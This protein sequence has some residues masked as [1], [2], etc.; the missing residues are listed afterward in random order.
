MP[1]LPEL[2][3]LLERIRAA[4][5][6]DRATPITERREH[7]HAGID[8]QQAHMVEPVPT[9]PRADHSV[10]VSV[11][12]I[13]VRVYRPEVG[14]AVGCHLFIHGGGWW[15]GTLDQSDLACSRLV[16]EVGCAVVSVDHRWSPEWRFPV[17]AEDCYAALSW[18]AASSAEL[19]FDPG[20]ISVGGVSSGANL[21]AATTLMARDRGGPDVIAQS[22]EVPILDLTLSPASID[23]L[24]EGYMLTRER[25]ALEVADY[26]DPELRTDPYASP[27]LA[28]DLA[29]LPPALIATAEYDLLRDDGESYAARLS[30]AG[31]PATAVRWPGHLHGSLGMTRVAPS[32]AEWHQR[33]HAFLRER[34]EL[35]RV[36]SGT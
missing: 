1:V 27:L 19:G 22:L 23:Q 20:R 36:R 11:G 18:V 24:A 12:E 14:E 6:P 21:A 9:A 33:Q 15:M 3:P 5:A 7:V 13:A 17:P 32:A 30:A 25:L 29:A 28:P 10:R 35:A 26:C 31:V 16:N 2:Q 4:G 8:M 34:H